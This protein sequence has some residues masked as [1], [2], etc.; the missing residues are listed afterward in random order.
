MDVQRL[1]LLRRKQFVFIN[2]SIVLAMGLLMLFIGTMAP[3]LP[4]FYRLIAAVTLL[5]ICGRFFKQRLSKWWFKLFPFMQELDEYEKIKLNKQQRKMETSVLIS[6]LLQAGLFIWL[7]FQVSSNQTFDLRGMG[8]SF[9]VLPLCVVLIIVNLSLL[10]HAKLVDHGSSEKLKNYFFKSWVFAII[11]G[12][13]AVPLI[14]SLILFTLF[15][16]GN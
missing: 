8:V 12:L 16:S 5:G 11:L 15:H 1:K 10:R 9:W 6:N 14:F 4:T 13:L 3:S 7:S 2:I